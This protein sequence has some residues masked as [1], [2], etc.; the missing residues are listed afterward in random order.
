[1]PTVHRVQLEDD[2]ETARDTPRDGPA[3]RPPENQA[4]KLDSDSVKRWCWIEG[5]THLKADP[6]PSHLRPPWTTVVRRCGEGQRE[7]GNGGGGGRG[8]GCLP[9]ASILGVHWRQPLHLRASVPTCRPCGGSL[10][11]G[12]WHGGD[13]SRAQSLRQWR[14]TPTAF[15]RRPS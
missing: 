14:D 3:W 7:D 9:R 8:Q 13:H 11:G 1:M 6:P 4:A 5:A 12:G 10:G 2:L 15:G